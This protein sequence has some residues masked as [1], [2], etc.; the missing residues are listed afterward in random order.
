MAT[1]NKELTDNQLGNV[2]ANVDHDVSTSRSSI[3]TMIST[4]DYH[5]RF[6]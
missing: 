1:T 2:N 4:S 6:D 5:R 3:D